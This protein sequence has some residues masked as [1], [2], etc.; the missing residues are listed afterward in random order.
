MATETASTGSEP[1][2]D[3]DV[4][5]EAATDGE[6]SANGDTPAEGSV[7]EA[8][9][10]VLN[11]SEEA[12]KMVLSLQAEE[13]DAEALGLRLE[14]TGAQGVEYSYDLSF[15]TI[16]DCANGY[17]VEESEGLTVMIPDDSVENLTGATLDLPSNSAQGGLVIR[18]PNRPD[19]LAG[20]DLEL[21]GSISDKVT[22][23]INAVINPGLA[24]HG[25][26]TTLVKVEDTTVYLSMGGGCQGCSMSA[27]TMTEGIRTQLMELIPEITE[28]VDDTDHSAGETPF[29]S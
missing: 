14:I 25:G 11:V 27:M 3:A 26:Y 2:T 19:P 12:R 20:I 21:T 7:E 29:Y 8:S 18:N 6:A 1:T 15:E 5:D 10:L 9:G 24:A 4:A 28:V 13:D 17:H 22:Q 23:L 16:A